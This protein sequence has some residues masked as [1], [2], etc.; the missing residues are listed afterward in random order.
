MYIVMELCLG[1]ELSD[2]L[3][4]RTYFKEEVRDQ[5]IGLANPNP[6]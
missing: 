1:G 6:N 2:E 3:K 5:A 4:K